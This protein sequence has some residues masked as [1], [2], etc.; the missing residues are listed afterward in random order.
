M[1]TRFAAYLLSSVLGDWKR[2][3]KEVFEVRKVLDIS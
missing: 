3:D 1:V 2:R